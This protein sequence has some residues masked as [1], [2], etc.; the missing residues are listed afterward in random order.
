MNEMQKRALILA[1]ASAV[2]IPAEGLRQWAYRDVAGVATICYGTTK[3]VKPGDYRTLEQCKALLN[4]D[5][6]ASIDTV[7]RC[8]RRDLSAEQTAAFAD[9]VYNLGPK[10]VC[11]PA[12]STLAR[13][14]QAGDVVG[15]CNELPKWVKATVAG[16]PVTLPGLVKRREAERALCLG[17]TSVVAIK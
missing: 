17:N 10:V 14:L 12:R 4:K 7:Q 13:K 16:V 3:G 8:A 11:D 15:A 5:M 1:L 2:A 9:A 6:L